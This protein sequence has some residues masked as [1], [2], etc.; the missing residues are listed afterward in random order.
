MFA[1]TSCTNRMPSQLFGRRTVGLLSA[2]VSSFAALGQPLEIG[3]LETADDSGISWQFWSCDQTG[4][5]LHCQIT[6]TMI[7]HEVEPTQ[8]DAILKKRLTETTPESFRREMG[9]TCKN[10]DAIQR[11]VESKLSAGKKPDGTTFARQEA[12]DIRSNVAHDSGLQEPHARKHTA[13]D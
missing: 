7:S 12:A 13:H 6:Q 9:D 5:T 8:K 11:E 10:V 1:K 3:H 2:L 4:T